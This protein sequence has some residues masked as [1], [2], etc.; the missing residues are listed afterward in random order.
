MLFHDIIINTYEAFVYNSIIF[1]R[2]I[3]FEVMMIFPSRPE[4][5]EQYWRRKY[6]ILRN[7]FL[8]SRL[9]KEKKKQKT[10]SGPV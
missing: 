8:Y 5:L 1:S 7:T 6:S 3:L 4:K 10:I 9:Q 2:R